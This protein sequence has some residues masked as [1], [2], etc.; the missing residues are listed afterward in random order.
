MWV[1]FAGE[2]L[3]VVMSKMQRNKGKRGEYI[4]RDFLRQIWPEAERGAQQSRRGDVMPDVE[5]TSFWPE[6]K[7][8]QN[9]SIH[10]ALLQAEAATDGRPVLIMSK[11]NR[12]PMLVTMRADDWVELVIEAHRGQG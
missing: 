1:V 7:F 2:G 4:A 3:A 9:P 12:E 10:K 8:G 11:R 5:G 6:V